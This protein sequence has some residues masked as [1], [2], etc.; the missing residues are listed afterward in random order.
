MKSD[1]EQKIFNR[2]HTNS[3][4]GLSLPQAAFDI[5]YL[6]ARVVELESFAQLTRD[7]IQL[8]LVVMQN[9]M[10]REGIREELIDILTKSAEVLGEKK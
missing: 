5:G 2:W 1:E 10:S 9:G 8:L 4:E 3:Y 7:K 6:T